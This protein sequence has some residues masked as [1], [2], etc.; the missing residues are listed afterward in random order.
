MDITLI[1]HAVIAL[2]TTLIGWACGDIYAGATFGAALFIGREHAQAEYR[3]IEQ[4]GYFKRSNLPWWGAF[5]YRVWS[6]SSMLDWIIPLL[7]AVILTCII[8]LLGGQ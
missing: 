5:D 6:L 8:I 7:A 1:E 3:W 4:Y 2:I